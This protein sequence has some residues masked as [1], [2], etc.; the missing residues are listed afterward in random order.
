MQII[1]ENAHFGPKLRFLQ[2]LQFLCIFYGFLCNFRLKM[3]IFS[4]QTGRGGGGAS[5][6]LLKGE[7]LDFELRGGGAVSLCTFVDPIKS[8]R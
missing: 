8:D 6:K 4:C 2:F 3:R 7:G 5:R 1:A